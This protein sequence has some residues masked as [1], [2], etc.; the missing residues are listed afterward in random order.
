MGNET[1]HIDQ[2]AQTLKLLGDPTRL[3]IMAL[4][5]HTECC[6]CEIVEILQMSQPSVSQHLKKLRDGGLVKERRGGRW[7]FYSLNTSHET[8]PIIHQVLAHLPDQK[9]KLK[10]LEDSGLPLQCRR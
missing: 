8:V 1:F 6:V 9:E 7:V 5:Q 4:V 10:A 3:T 2:A